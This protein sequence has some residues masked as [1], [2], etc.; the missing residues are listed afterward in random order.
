MPR[1]TVNRGTK[2]LGQTNKDGIFEFNVNPDVR[3]ITLTFTPANI[4]KYMSTTKVR[5]RINDIVMI[6]TVDNKSL[7]SKY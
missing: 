3:K 2:E 6:Y 7:W 5:R 1:V 4:K